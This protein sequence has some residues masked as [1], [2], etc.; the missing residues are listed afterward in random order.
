[1]A[2]GAN[3][4]LANKYQDLHGPREEP[5]GRIHAWTKWKGREEDFFVRFKNTASCTKASTTCW[6]E[7]TLS[8]A[9]LSRSDRRVLAFFA[10]CA[11]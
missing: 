8:S 10:A 5:G 11:G 6:L 7:P 9:C 4:R 1:M 3:W 2:S